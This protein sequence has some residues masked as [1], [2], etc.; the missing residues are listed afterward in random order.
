MRIE[1]KNLDVVRRSVKS[2]DKHLDIEVEKRLKETALQI[3][4]DAKKALKIG[5]FRRGPR[6]GKIPA[7]APRF[8]HIFS[9]TGRL[10]N[11]LRVESRRRGN[12]TIVRTYSEASYA[13]P[14]EY[15]S[16]FIKARAWLS[17]TLEKDLP[18][19]NKNVNKGV[20]DA[21]KKAGLK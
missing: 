17:R 4:K 8:P 9:R 6:G 21:I 3:K 7:P 12:K 11:S 10:A 13:A 19:L 2:L 14:L 18:V 15:G 20:K 1:I 5:G 16:R